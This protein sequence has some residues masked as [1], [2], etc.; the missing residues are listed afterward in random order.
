MEAL[1]SDVIIV[2]N[3]PSNMMEGRKRKQYPIFK[4]HGSSS[5]NF[6]LREVL[7]KLKS[8]K[9]IGLILNDGGCLQVLHA[10]IF[11]FRTFF[12]LLLRN[13]VH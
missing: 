10:R 13:H 11:L 3:L 12:D 5:P 1:A 9:V 6:Y 4:P 8:A 2:K 7:P